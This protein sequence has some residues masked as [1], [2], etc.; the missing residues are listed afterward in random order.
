MKQLDVDE[1]KTAVN[2]VATKTWTNIAGDRMTSHLVSI[3]FVKR[4]RA[5]ALCIDEASFFNE[6]RYTVVSNEKNVLS[7]LPLLVHITLAYSRVG[8]R[9]IRVNLAIWD[10]VQTIKSHNVSY[11]DQY[12]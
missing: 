9:V 11:A 5:H 4:P 2:S 6:I 12:S 8:T 3:C 10:V 1:Q 7:C